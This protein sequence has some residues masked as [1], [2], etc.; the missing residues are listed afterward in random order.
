MALELEVYGVEDPYTKKDIIPFRWDPQIL[1]ELRGPGAGSFN[2][3]PEDATDPDNEGLFAWRNI[4]KVRDTT[5]KKCLGGFLIQSRSEVLVNSD[6]EGGRF[7]QFSGEGLRTWFHDATVYPMG[8][9]NKYAAD[10]RVFS[11]ASEQGAWY[12]PAQWTSPVNVRKYLQSGNAWGTAPANWPDEPNAYWIWDRDSNT[13]APVG[14]VYFRREFTLAADTSCS[15]YIAVDNTYN[16]YMDAQNIGSYPN[17]DVSNFQQVN[18]IDFTLGPGSH[19]LAIEATNTG[20]P[21]G[22]IAALRSNGNPNAPATAAS[23]IFKTGDAGWKMLAYPAT[24]PGWTT[25]MILLKL[26]A[27]AEA[28]GITFPTILQPT[29]TETLDSNG[30]PW[31][32]AQAWEFD[33]GAEYTTVLDKIEE[34]NADI[35]VD[36]ETYELNAVKQR[37]TDRSVDSGQTD[38]VALIIG[39]NVTEGSVEGDADMKNALLLKTADGWF[40]KVSAGPGSATYGRMEAQAA[41]DAG[42]AFADTVANYIFQIH[43][44]PVTNVSYGFLADSE[45]LPWQTVFPGDYLLAP[46]TNRQLTKQ[47]VYSLSATEDAAGNTIYAAEFGTL[48]K[49]KIDRLE[50]RLDNISNGSAASIQ[51]TTSNVTIPNGGKGSFTSYSTGGGSNGGGSGGSVTPPAAPTSLLGDSTGYFAPEGTPKSRFR[52][53]WNA[54][55]QDTSGNAITPDHYDVWARRNRTLAQRTTTNLHTNPSFETGVSDAAGTNATATQS[56]TWAQY[57]TRSLKITPSGASVSSYATLGGGPGGLRSGMTPGNWYNVSAYM[58]MSAVQGGTL[59]QNARTLAVVYRDAGGNLQQYVSRAIPNVANTT[60]RASLAVYIPPGATEA[61]V[62]VYNGTST[63]NTMDMYVDGVQVT[64]GTPLHAYIDGSLTSDAMR[65]Y[66]WTGTAHASTSTV[67]VT[68]ANIFVGSVQNNAISLDGLQ[69]GESW[70]VGVAAVLTAT[71]SHSAEINLTTPFPD[72]QLG[73]PTDPLVNS[74]FGF[75]SVHWDGLLSG[76]APDLSYAYTYALM[77]SSATDPNFVA[78]GQSINTTGDIIVPNLAV[79]SVKWFKLVAVDKAGNISGTSQPISVTVVAGASGGGTG[80]ANL[81][82]GSIVPYGGASA[83]SGWLLA[84]GSAVSRTTYADLFSVF[85]TSYGAGNGSTTFNLPNLKGAIPVGM[86]SSQTEFSAL[87]TSGGE[88][89]HALTSDELPVTQANG[90]MNWSAFETTATN[91]PVVSTSGTRHKYTA[92]RSANAHNNL[93]PYVTVTYIVKADSSGSSGGGGAGAAIVDTGY[94]TLEAALVDV[95]TGGLLQVT[96]A[97]TRA[98]TFTINKSC[99]VQFVGG[100][101]TTTLDSIAAITVAADDVTLDSPKLIGTTSATSS[102]GAGIYAAGGAASTPLQNLRILRPDISNFTQNAISLLFCKNFL[103]RE[104]KITNIAYAGIMMSSCSDGQILGGSVTNLTMPSPLVNAYGIA[105]S[106]N[107][108]AGITTNPQSRDILIDGVTVDGVPFWEGI[109]T[110]AGINIRVVNCTVRNCRYGIAFVPGRNGSST[111]VLAPKNALI[112]NNT[113]DSG[114]TNGTLSIGVELIGCSSGVGFFNN[115]DFATGR[116]TGNTIIECGNDAATSG[117]A[118]NL[119]DTQGAVVAN[120]NFVNPVVSAIRLDYNNKDAVIQGNQATDAW[121]NTAAYA[122]MI[123][124]FSPWNTAKISGNTLTRGSKSATTINSYGIRINSQTATQIVEQGNDFTAAATPYSLA[125][126]IIRY[127]YHGIRNAFVTALPTAGAWQAGAQALLTAPPAGGSPGWVC[128]TAG[129]ASAGTW[130]AST[131]Y[132]AS[133][134]IKTSTGKVLECVVAGTSGTGEPSPTVID[135]VF[136]DGTVTWV[137]RAAA[138]AVFKAMPALAA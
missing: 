99:T 137:Y 9:L 32:D 106:Y 1:E 121:T 10:S 43:D 113:I 3:R 84:D 108:L 18:R 23:T 15:L 97:Y 52:L 37:G 41:T 134:Y 7:I 119:Q 31:A 28:R 132:S 117:T 118:M 67:V 33:V 105:A 91:A 90:L 133:T 30:T 83:P 116:I 70:T 59:D 87:G 2:V 110:H 129:G 131:A 109:D 29:F 125:T 35:W 123:Q 19:V 98:T 16:V 92:V 55:T 5:T 53:R 38:R 24:V 104:S 54:V 126:P 60:Y 57:G 34:L 114:Y 135:G 68:D 112:A 85:G 50:K 64:L 88:K 40:E 26:L 39:K 80:A 103:I 11:F 48:I 27:E 138:S 6:E 107:E 22:V 63:T 12:V 93:Q 82:V 42:K 61:W 72:T 95:P 111:Y 77:G 122:L 65:T 36:P 81:P 89:A 101:I 96:R 8:G 76:A 56:T 21:A 115:Y 86:D 71:S 128:T 74:A 124:T 66:A 120:N 49:D 136:T 25:G 58:R 14:T 20:G 17:A 73:I 78:V 79:G 130:A 51:G 69:P 46:D 4:I 127:D 75:V 94:P 44:Q 47:R 62:R 45:V 102:T 100:S 13:S